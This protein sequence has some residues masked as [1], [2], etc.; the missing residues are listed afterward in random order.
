MFKAHA[1]IVGTT[2]DEGG[3]LRII[4]LKRASFVVTPV[5]SLARHSVLEEHADFRRGGAASSSILDIRK[6]WM[7][8]IIVPFPLRNLGIFKIEHKP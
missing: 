1:V 5:T 7:V 8:R 4:P 3:A 2:P 6:L